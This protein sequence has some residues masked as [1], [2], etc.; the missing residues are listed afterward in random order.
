MWR[1][2]LVGLAIVIAGYALYNLLVT[3]D[4]ERVEDEVE[5]A[6]A[7]AREGGDEAAEAVL[8]ILADDYDGEYPRRSI[9]IHVRRFV[10][11]K[12][13]RKLTTGDYKAVWKGDEIVIPIL[14]L[15]VETDRGPLRAILRV[16][17]APRDGAWK[18]VNVG[19]WR[20]ER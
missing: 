12:R 11:E 16:T 6:L 4:L 9:E 1:T 17:F 5:R 19:R 2:L 10:G 14:R 8:D 13:V 15:D 7:H 3:T 20:L 18:V